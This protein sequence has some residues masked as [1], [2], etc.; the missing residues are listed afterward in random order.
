MIAFLYVFTVAQAVALLFAVV[1]IERLTRAAKHHEHVL[2]L[3][4]ETLSSSCVRPDRAHRFS[5]MVLNEEPWDARSRLCG[6]PLVQASLAPG[7]AP[8]GDR[9]V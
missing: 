6:S 9:D 3:T 2:R 8:K 4:L 7:P 1:R 5:L